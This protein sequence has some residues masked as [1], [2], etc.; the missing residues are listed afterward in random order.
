MKLKYTLVFTIISFFISTAG[1]AQQYTDEEIGFDVE[2][3]TLSLKEH[4]VKDENISQQI[5]FMRKMQLSQYLDLRAYKDSLSKKEKS[6][7]VSNI[8]NRS[9]A[10]TDIPQ[11]EKDALL[12]I[13]NSLGGSGWINNTGWNASNPV[14]SWDE[15]T[16]TG[17]YG[18][19]VEDNHVVRLDLN[20]N[21][22][23]KDFSEPFPNI[24]ALSKL[25]ILYLTGGE[26]KGTIPDFSALTDLEILSL[27]GNKFEGSIP[28]SIYSLV[29][30]RQLDLYSNRL[31]GDYSPIGQYLTK[32][33]TLTL[34]LNRFQYINGIEENNFAIPSSFQNLTLLRDLELQ[35]CGLSQNLEL[36]GDYLKN[37]TDLGLS[38]NNFS[39]ALPQNFTNLTKLRSL[40]ILDNKFSDI[41]ALPTL[42]NSLETIWASNNLIT[43]IPPAVGTMTKL[44][45][46]SL[47][48]NK[49][50]SIPQYMQNCIELRTLTLNRNLLEGKIPDLTG[51]TKLKSFNIEMNKLRFI[52]FIA[53]YPS[54][55][56]TIYDYFYY[57]DQDYVDESQFINKL[58]GDSVTLTMY[59]DGRY[60]DTDT[61]LWTKNGVA[62]P[63][64]TNREYTI[65]YLRT[66][67]A[68][69]YACVS[70]NP[71][72]TTESAGQK[73]ILYRRSIDLRVQP[74]ACY[75]MPGEIKISKEKVGINESVTFSFETTATDVT[76]QWTLYGYNNAIVG[77]P[78]TS[79]A[80]QSYSEPGSY[81]VSLVITEKNGCKTYKNIS[82]LVCADINASITIP[83]ETIT[84]NQIIPFSITANTTNISYQ[85]T[86]YNSDNTV[87][88]YA[89]TSSVSKSYT[90]PGNYRVNVV[91]TDRTLGCKTTLDK[92]ITVTGECSIPGTLISNPGEEGIS[93]YQSTYFRFDTQATGLTYKWTVTNPGNSVSEISSDQYAYY[94]FQDGPGTYK[95]ILEV[96][97]Y[98]GCTLKL[99]KNY[100]LI[101]NCD[102][103]KYN[104]IILNMG[105]WGSSNILIN[106][107][108]EFVFYPYSNI[109]LSE[110]SILWEVLNSNGDV[111][112][113]AVTQ[114]YSYTPT[115][116]GN[117]TLQFKTVDS[118]GCIN[119][120][121]IDLTA[122]ES[123]AYSDEKL[124]GS[125][126]IDDE[127][128]V[129]VPTIQINQTKVL[130]FQP[131]KEID[132]AYTYKWEIY[133]VNDQ[134]IK[135]G[136]QENQ[137]IT[138]STPG[139][140]K[141]K[142]DIENEVGCIL[143]FSKTIQCLVENACTIN[144][145]N[146]EIVK[147]IYKNLLKNLLVRSL[148]GETDE[149]INTSRAT[150]QFLALKPYI[151]NGVKDKVY[152]Y[153]T[154][155]ND[156]GKLT[157]IRFSFAPDREYDAQVLVAKGLWNYEQDTDE[158]IGQFSL[159]IDSE[160]Y[161]NIDQF[162]SSDD[163]LI[164]C[165]NQKPQNNSQAK[166]AIGL[167]D[168]Y[169]ETEIRYVDFC[170]T[171]ACLPTIGTILTGKSITY[172]GVQAN[173]NSKKSSL[174]Q[175]R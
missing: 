123:C 142:L 84:T 29:K 121:A 45:Q 81:L 104:G 110:M 28:S 167:N 102:W 158:T 26:I 100:N 156:L 11:S 63:G 49:I 174:K 160:I 134:L 25:K 103:S 77:T 133:D 14:A 20:Y 6:K 154:T 96:K 5:S 126:I 163:Y 12:A 17:W 86:F 23:S 124:N 19:T 30:L 35:H 57:D 94:Y 99:E 64:A 91:L 116:L 18:V 111:I 141:V 117:Y 73:M 168:C 169:L 112:E 55:K 175:V 122:V 41:S 10:V 1:F 162:T 72:M 115:V 66:E 37:L 78:T 153:T 51:L 109:D 138:F 157:S 44:Q 85:W 97:D 105:N 139:F 108:N 159:R 140:Y 80:T 107:P 114:E 79:T 24:D 146:S 92:I 149:H 43:S 118:N 15:Q 98:S 2:K 68:G 151:T 52:D 136:N 95:L 150:S 101:Y 148:S 143:H 53:E 129:E 128:N 56:S 16:G 21:R 61:Y 39:G 161:I 75:T 38:S 132:R 113:S 50:T 173:K 83:T 87:N 106:A 48:S 71:L 36:I 7:K 65:P 127:N 8:T 60:S 131:D 171:E 172:P 76:Y 59:A 130:S 170:P 165:Y 46:L 120:F 74:P 147:G 54:Y 155:R 27:S 145:P 58:T 69:I 125:I 137:S 166:F 135:T 90:S 144:N 13:Y 67:N 42:N 152:N 32:L 34:G 89:N 33:T 3:A 88:S 164:S 4:E 40:V 93:L 31:D 70:K 9:V 62:I 22:L 119:E 47:E 82:V